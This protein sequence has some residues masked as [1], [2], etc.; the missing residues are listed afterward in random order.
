MRLSPGEL[1]WAF[2]SAGR[3]PA[4]WS[5]SLWL[6]APWAAFF[7]D[8]LNAIGI[9]GGGDLVAQVIGIVSVGVFVSAA[10]AVLW[11]LLKAVMGIRVSEEVEDL[12][13]DRAELG[14]EAYPEFGAG[15]QRV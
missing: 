8:L 3:A 9:F 5:H 12:G 15:S 7:G 13:L 2:A 11:L 1:L 10:S 14:M 4:G 6:V